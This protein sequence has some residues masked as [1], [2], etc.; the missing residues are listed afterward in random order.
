[1]LQKTKE[2]MEKELRIQ[3]EEKLVLGLSGGMDSV[4]LFTILHRLGYAL[5]VVHVNHGIRGQ[6][7][8][9][10]EAFVKDLCKKA[11]VPFHG[12]S[13]HVPELARKEHLS[14]EE[15]G[16]RVRRKAFEQVRQDTGASWIAL[17]HHGDDRAE[18]MLFHLSRGTGL[19]GLT[20]M[21]PQEG[22]YIRPFLWT[23]RK[24][25]QDYVE[26]E[27]I[28]YVEDSTNAQ[29]A[30]TRN[31]IRHSILPEFTA[32]NEKAVIHINETIEKLEVVQKF[33]ETSAKKA[34]ETCCIMENNRIRIYEKEFMELDPALQ[35]PLLQQCL[36]KLGTRG[37]NITQEHFSMILHLFS[38]QTGRQISLPF[39]LTARKT[40]GAVEL[41]YP[42][43]EMIGE[44]VFIQGSGDYEFLGAWLEVTI[45]PW[46][47][48]KNFSVKNYTKCF[49]YDRIKGNVMIR[50]RR[51]GDYLTIHRQGGKK[52]LQDYLVNEKIPREQ[53]DQV[54]LLAEDSH[55]LWVVGKR[56]SE[57][58]KITEETKRVLK[59][60]FKGG[61][62]H[63]LQD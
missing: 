42:Q 5:E 25:I 17:A 63:E 19:K 21:K 61:K 13:Y 12:F 11:Q 43:K 28:S 30:Y 56:I 2:Y 29:D 38:L 7:A 34:M 24:K 46:D 40:Y 41:F 4:C 62:E 50:T 26:K 6:E 44:P 60:R 8:D 35:I 1:M 48:G 58:Y 53:R 27:K 55:V 18:T 23:E 54:I 39:G 52:S 10:D 33:L 16:R 9:R 37:K 31:R 3:P 22:V 59:I 15:A 20:S 51:P 47:P 57:Y 36:L 49:D 45:E 32:L 14:I